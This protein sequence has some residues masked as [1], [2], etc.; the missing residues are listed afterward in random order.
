MLVMSFQKK[1]VLLIAF[2]KKSAWSQEQ[3]SR[4]LSHWYCSIFGFSAHV[5]DTFCVFDV[6]VDYKIQ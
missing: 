2:T 4:S 6:T 1:V 5:G 3:D